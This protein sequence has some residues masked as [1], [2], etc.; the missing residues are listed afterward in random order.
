[1]VRAPLTGKHAGVEVGDTSQ[2]A[3]ELPDAAI[4]SPTPMSGPMRA[5]S[6]S[7]F[8]QGQVPF[9]DVHAP[10]QEDIGVLPLPIAEP[11]VVSLGEG[12]GHVGGSFRLEP[13][14]GQPIAPPQRTESSSSHKSSLHPESL[15]LTLSGQPLGVLVDLTV[16]L[17]EASRQAV[18]ELELVEED[19]NVE[20]DTEVSLGPEVVRGE[21][22][23]LEEAGVI[24]ETLSEALA[25]AEPSF[26]SANAMK[27]GPFLRS[28]CLFFLA[29]FC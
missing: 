28:L 13:L 3:T 12:S 23:Q 20:A 27:T 25:D 22:S 1:M 21:G 6:P 4:L 5:E 17:E 19:A 11:V 18:R 16:E 15:G 7:I 10:S 29:K 26:T 2:R 8:K 14:V 9:T 24:R